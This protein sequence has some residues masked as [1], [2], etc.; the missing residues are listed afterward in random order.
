[1]PTELNGIA[2]RKSPFLKK[3]LQVVKTF[4]K[5]SIIEIIHCRRKHGPINYGCY[6]NF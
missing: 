1:M 3:E 4:S 2:G 5:H 6:G